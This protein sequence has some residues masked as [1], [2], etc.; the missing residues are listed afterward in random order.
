MAMSLSKYFKTIAWICLGVLSIIGFYSLFHKDTH[1]RFSVYTSQSLY[2]IDLPAHGLC[3]IQEESSDPILV[4]NTS[5]EL[6][7]DLEELTARD[8]YFVSLIGDDAI[9]ADPLAKD[10]IWVLH[11]DQHEPDKP[12]H[13]DT[14]GMLTLMGEDWIYNKIR[15]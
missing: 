5:K 13:A 7:D 9:I 6:L 3:T 11:I 4:Y 15:P 10:S 8:S 2:H 14:I 1:Y 12:Y